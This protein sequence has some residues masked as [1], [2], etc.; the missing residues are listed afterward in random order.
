M[1]PLIMS[2][3]FFMGMFAGYKVGHSTGSTTAWQRYLQERR[4]AELEAGVGKRR[5]ERRRSLL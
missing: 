2:L 3:A 4:R 1:T 5:H